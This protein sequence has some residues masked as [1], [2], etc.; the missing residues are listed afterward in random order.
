MKTNTITAAATLRLTEERDIPLLP[1]HWSARRPQAFRQIPA[2]AWLAE[3]EVISPE[4]HRLFLETDH[5]LL[6]R[7][8]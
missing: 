4:R 6:G 5:S 3:S 8:R 1:R 7:G 2:L